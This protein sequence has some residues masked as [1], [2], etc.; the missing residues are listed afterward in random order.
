[1]L[2]KYALLALVLVSATQFA[3]SQKKTSASYQYTVDLTKVVDDKVYVE[4]LPPPISKNEVTFYLPKMIPGTYA[5]EDYGRFVSEFTAL[6]KKGN[7]LT[8]EKLNDNAWKIKDASKLSKISYWIEDSYDT[9]LSEPEIFQPAGTNI[10]EG[11]NFVLNG[12]GFFGYL[13]G[14]RD[15]P[16]QLSFIR[17]ENFY[18]SSGLIAAEVGKPLRSINREK[19]NENSNKRVDI[20]KTIDYDE[21]V[22][23]PLMYAKTDTAVIKVAN[24]EVLIGCYSPNGKITAKQIAESIKEVLMAQKDFLGGTLPVDKYAFI[25]YFTDQPVL[26]YGALEHSHSSFYYM[27]EQ[28]IY[29]MNA[30][31]RD[32]AAH[33]FFHIV[34]PLN[35]HSEQIEHFDFNDPKMSQH[36][37]LY[38]GVTEYNAGSVQVKYGLITPEEYLK[39]IRTKMLS[40]ES[41]SDSISFTDLSKFTLDKYKD[42]YPNVYM[43]GALIG[44]CLDIKLLKLSNGKYGVRNLLLDLSKKYGKSKA[45]K[46]DALFGE[47]T[48][49]TYPEIG[50]FFSR[51]VSG[52]EPL[53][54]AEVFKAVG[55]TYAA[56]QSVED[57]SLGISQSIIG[58]AQVEG[59][60]KLKIASTENMNAMGVAVGFKTDDVLVKINGEQIP[61]LGPELG[62]FIQKHMTALPTLKTV[63]FTVLRK[64]GETMK[65]TELSAPV[66]KIAIVQKHILA[67]DATATP[68]QLALRSA[69]LKP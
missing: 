10:E 11:K 12:A 44:M 43:K 20:F 36:L 69:W 52:A 57:Y 15:I 3:F 26:S 30:Q 1:M 28:N 49:M 18:G 41:F 37:W 48:K 8:T 46:D 6:D 31:L 24:A 29:Q 62:S 25:F 45:F 50:D 51:Y 13:E 60:P 21:L 63:S 33:E 9:K 53:P 32:F 34:T 40:A 2:L 42:E 66:Q 38:E 67:F 59:K 19:G 47:I 27:P 61:D 54:C 35:I 16:F 55:I 17:P 65:E 23:S 58:V 5:I 7:K 64:D 56:E 68:E 4:L 22:D 14:A 39:V